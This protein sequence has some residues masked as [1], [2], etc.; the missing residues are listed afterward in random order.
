MR[1]PVWRKSSSSWITGSGISAVRAER[2]P[3]QT[4]LGA[5]ELKLDL[6]ALARLD[7][8]IVRHIQADRRL[9]RIGALATAVTLAGGAIYGFAFGLWRAPE[10]ALYSAIK[11]PLLLLAVVAASALINGVLAL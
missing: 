4:A 5:D 11:L 6:R 3:V 1:A 7:E 9:G 10:Q 2:N 8:S